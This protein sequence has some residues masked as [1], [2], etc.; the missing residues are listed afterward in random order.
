MHYH[1]LF[2]NTVFVRY[3][4]DGSQPFCTYDGEN[5]YKLKKTLLIVGD[6]SH[7]GSKSAAENGTDNKGKDNIWK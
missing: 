7:P 2:I 5:S 3:N 1:V 6:N 4:R